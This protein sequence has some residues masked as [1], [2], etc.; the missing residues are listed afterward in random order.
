MATGDPSRRD[1]LAWG[2]FLVVLCFVAYAN[3]M[4]GTFTYDDKAIVRDNPRIR[5]PSHMPEILSTSY[6]GGPRGSG[7]AYRPVLL[8]SYAAQWWIHG[9]DA[10]AF[11]TVNV[12]L[13]AAATIL[14]AGLLLRV[15]ISAATAA[16]A[17]L[18]FA[19]APVHVEAVTSLVGR[20]ETLAAVLTL[21]FLHV[22][23]RL[24][25]GGRHRVVRYAA[26]LA[27]YALGILTKESAA[28]APGLLF[29]LLAFRE[30]GSLRRRFATAWRRGWP[31]YAG[32]AAMLAG[33]FALRAWVL[34]G[35]LRA[36]GTNVFEVENALASLPRMQRAVNA[37]VLL[38]RYAGRTIVPFHLSADESAWS[39]RPLSVLSA[40]GLAAVLLL[41]ALAAVAVARLSSGSPIALGALFFGVAFLPAANLLYPTGTIFGERIAYLPSAGIFLALAAA[42]AGGAEAARDIS[43]AGRR[44]AAVIAIVFAARTV[45]RNAV[46]WSDWSLFANSVATAPG[47]A[48]AH[49]NWAYINAEAEHPQEAFD[50]YA[51]AVRIYPRYWDALAGR[52]RMEKELG[53]LTDAEASYRAALAANPAY[54]NGFF[55][56]G[57]VHEAQGR[58]REAEADYRTGLAKN[59][60]SLPLAYRLASVLTDEEAPAVEAA[61]RRALTL[62]QHSAATHA[63]YAS[64][65]LDQGR[66]REAVVQAHEALRIDP[67][68]SDA[69]RVL[70]DRQESS[71]GSLA[72][73]LGLEKACRASRDQEDLDAL[74]KVAR[75]TPEYRARFERVRPALQ[76]AIEP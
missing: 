31:V 24:A 27:L 45:T 48:K 1:R 67:D 12:L 46:W 26:A 43:P 2:L 49:Y 64:W 63:D 29:L 18:F 62:G 37:C 75:A 8:A 70:A 72:A 9:K 53:R 55:G 10:M 74:A 47:S 61:W 34:G 17:S 32:G 52:G 5:A 3:G 56:L 35:F 76:R 60:D 11:H 50:H 58:L 20:G 6:F 73:A 21:V 30:P 14:L 25:E 42:C 13:H 68:S 41:G 51:K 59:P 66:D 69:W 33:T 71:R 28:M 40:L 22:S 15:G 23:M 39:I 65:L 54:E 19:L 57:V 7:T 38:L 36:P 4:T 44:A 16:L